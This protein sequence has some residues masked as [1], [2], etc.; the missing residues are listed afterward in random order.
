MYSNWEEQALNSLVAIKW[1]S[2]IEVIRYLDCLRLFIIMTPGKLS[3]TYMP[4]LVWEDEHDVHNHGLPARKDA[5]FP[6]DQVYI[7]EAIGDWGLRLDNLALISSIMVNTN[8]LER[9]YPHV[10]TPGDLEQHALRMIDELRRMVQGRIDFINRQKFEARYNLDWTNG[11]AQVSVQSMILI[12]SQ[13]A[14][15]IKTEGS[16]SAS[17][18]SRERTFSASPTPTANTKQEYHT[19]GEEPSNH[20]ENS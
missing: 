6:S 18:E 20:S 17:N 11:T 15:N 13:T 19:P 9:K 14:N 4:M 12:E 5:R 2:V 10:T 3:E 8:K 16:S 1:Y 7:C